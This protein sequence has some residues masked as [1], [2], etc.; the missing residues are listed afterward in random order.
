MAFAWSVVSK[1]G[2]TK[3]KEIPALPPSGNPS[4]TQP[5]EGAELNSLMPQPKEAR[6][7][8][9]NLPNKSLTHPS[10]KPY[11]P[12]QKRRADLR[13]RGRVPSP[14]KKQ[15]PVSERKEMPLPGKE[16]TPT[17]EPV[18]LSERK[19]TPVPGKKW[20]SL[21]GKKEL[22]LP[23]ESPQPKSKTPW[24]QV[25]RPDQPAKIPAK[26]EA[27][28]P[29]L[30]KMETPLQKKAASVFSVV[31]VQSKKPVGVKP[32]LDSQHV[33]L[34]ETKEVPLPGK[35]EVSLP[36]KKEVS[37]PE[38]KT[39]PAPFPFPF[40]LPLPRPKVPTDK[41]HIP[42]QV[43]TPV[44]PQEGS[45]VGKSVSVQPEKAVDDEPRPASTVRRRFRRRKG[46]RMGSAHKPSATDR[47]EPR[48]DIKPEEGV[49][50]KPKSVEDVDNKPKSAE[51]VDNKPKL[52][53]RDNKPKP[54][55]DVD[56]KPKP[57]EEVHTKPQLAEEAGDKIPVSRPVIVVSPIPA[58]PAIVV[59][60]AFLRAPI[61]LRAMVRP[62]TLVLEDMFGPPAITAETFRRIP[63]PRRSIGEGSFSRPAEMSG[64][65]VDSEA[66]TLV[67]Q[68]E[69]ETDQHSNVLSPVLERFPIRGAAPA[70]HWDKTRASWDLT[71]RTSRSLP[72]LR[73]DSR[74]RSFGG[75]HAPNLG[76]D[77]LPNPDS[78]LLQ[79]EPQPPSLPGSPA[80]AQTSN[81]GPHV[82]P[83]W[84]EDI[85]AHIAGASAHLG[86]VTA[87]LESVS[88]FFGG[89]GAS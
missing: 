62:T 44:S 31:S 81:L 69:A 52:K 89:R 66:E 23:D 83:A 3:K 12:P 78:V 84:Y 55:E 39:S 70:R 88:V 49:D 82:T 30:A 27:Q 64:Q 16:E 65:D 38:K 67:S 56:N 5:N 17:K 24:A 80:E 87:M 2:K 22:S 35:E 8:K 50:N 86:A 71:A 46:P 33:P 14:D 41:V 79:D 4:L 77:G 40:P 20:V 53:V 48:P 76:G 15:V 18:T 43:K 85:K 34:S 1:G 42:P 72:D 37:L 59:S 11:V 68:P 36:I 29:P 57:E 75:S 74:R 26:D 45:A 47:S 54:E 10:A 51:D 73:N 58:Q 6:G 7:P 63:V 32:R 9:I 21:R 25:A 13:T 61:P 28:F 60:G 19:E